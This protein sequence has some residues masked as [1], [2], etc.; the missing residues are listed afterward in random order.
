MTTDLTSE[1]PSVGRAEGAACA[2]DV[3]RAREAPLPLLPP[4]SPTGGSKIYGM[5]MGGRERRMSEAPALDLSRVAEETDESVSSRGAHH[6]HH[7]HA[8]QH[9]PRGPPASPSK[10]NLAERRRTTAR[11]PEA[12]LEAFRPAAPASASGSGSA[13]GSHSN[14]GSGSGSGSGSP[15][16]KL[17]VLIAGDAPAPRRPTHRPRHSLDSPGAGAAGLLPRTA[18]PDSGLSASPVRV[19][20][21]RSSTQGGR[22]APRV[23]GAGSGGG[24]SPSPSP[25]GEAPRRAGAGAGAA[26]APVPVPFPRAPG[27]PPSPSPRTA[28]LDADR[29]RAA[30]GRFQSDVEGSARRARPSSYDELG[31]R[32]PLRSRFESMVNL[33]AAA[34]HGG[35]NGQNG[36]AGEGAD[37]SAV[38]M[39][40]VVREEGKPPTH[41]VGLF[42]FFLLLSAVWYQA[43]TILFYFFTLGENS[44]WATASGGGNSA[45][46]TAR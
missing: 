41:F 45:R 14:S 30:R 18:S 27:E 3:R 44:N 6:H 34:G 42:F 24:E 19:A 15:R 25:D 17:A 46:C 36:Q 11:A 16:R 2:E 40:L 22:Y 37:G 13:S 12:L 33:G 38:R 31:A 39:R 20:L 35:G 4:A 8:H 28:R 21:R 7:N 9:R 26:T 10:H 29:P 5:G 1:A 23:G 32:P 43:L